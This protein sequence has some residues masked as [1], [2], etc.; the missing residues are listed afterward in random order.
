MH[1]LSKTIR[2]LIV[3]AIFV[4]A[5]SALSAQESIGVGD[6][7]AGELDNSTAE[8]MVDAAGGELLVVTL[9]SDDF[10][11]YLTLLDSDGYEIAYDDDGAGGLN[12]R[13]A[14]VA[15][16]DGVYSLSVASFGDEPATG[17]AGRQ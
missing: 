9:I 14:F 4:V 10:D 1:N 15:P 8:F 16:A 2:W 6:T 13:L 12:S 11:A 5:L 17:P 3:L 7:V